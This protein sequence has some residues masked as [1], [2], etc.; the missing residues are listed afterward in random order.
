MI[1]PSVEKANERNLNL[2]EFLVRATSHKSGFLKRGQVVRSRENN[3]M[4]KMW[5]SFTQGRY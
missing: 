2:L 1:I 5:Y 3:E 4:S